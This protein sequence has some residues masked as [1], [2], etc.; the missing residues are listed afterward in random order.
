MDQKLEVIGEGKHLR[1]VRKDGW[2]YAERARPVRAV[3]IAAVTDDAKLVLTHE[4]RVPVNS[5]VIGFPAGLVG[6]TEG[7]EDEELETATRRELIEE[8]GFEPGHVEFL[9]R[10][11]TSS[12]MVDEIIAIMLATQLRRVGAGGGIG[13]ESIRVEEVSLAEV[14]AWLRA[15][16]AEGALVD[17]KVYTGLYF[18]RTNGVI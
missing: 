6:D 12:G 9:T 8:A 1:L 2:E 16:V 15:R 17:P 10:G 5:I 14:D 13:S 7:D 18:L 11:P 3:F 4:Y